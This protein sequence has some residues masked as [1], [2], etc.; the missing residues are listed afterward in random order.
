MELSVTTDYARDTGNPQPYL[1]RIADAGFS[2]IHWCHHWCTDFMYS[3][4][5]IDQIEEW[6]KDYGLRLLDLH[7]TAGQEKNWGSQREYERLAGLELVRNRIAMASQLGSDVIIMH[8]P[9]ESTPAMFR[10]SLNELRPF[11]QEH[12]VRIA[13]E[14]GDLSKIGELLSEYDPGYVGLCYDSGHGNVSG[15]G[16]DHLEELKDRLISVHLH[17][18]D[19]T[20]DQH[21]PLFSGTV[22]WPRLAEILAGCAYTKCVS[23]EVTMHNSGID[24]E[25]AFLKHTFE[26]GTRFSQMIEEQRHTTEQPDGAVTQESA[27]SAAP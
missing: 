24:D 14:N 15:S 19:G 10:K 9:A 1:R 16:L 5:E 8:A 2:H 3:K 22:D 27:R 21:N 4:W 7:A 17:D 18:N 11:A 20:G 13:I 12:H 6:L 26:T 23:M 25:M